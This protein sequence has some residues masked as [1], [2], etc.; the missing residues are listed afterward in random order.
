MKQ[1]PKETQLS[2]AQIADA[3]DVAD[4]AIEVDKRAPGGRLQ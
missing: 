4:K 2:G 3:M 1:V